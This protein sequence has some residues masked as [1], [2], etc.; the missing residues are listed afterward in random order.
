MAPTPL[1]PQ[2][3]CLLGST[4]VHAGAEPLSPA[5]RWLLRQQGW[6]R[7][8]PCARLQD[9]CTVGTCIVPQDS[10][11]V[12]CTHLWSWPSPL[13]GKPISV[14]GKWGPQRQ[15]GPWG[16][17]GRGAGAGWA[18]PRS[19]ATPPAE[20]GPES[21]RHTVSPSLS[22]PPSTQCPQGTSVGEAG[23][24][25]PNGLEGARRT[26]VWHHLLR[27]VQSWRER[28]APRPRQVCWQRA[29]GGPPCVHTLCLGAPGY[30]HAC[31]G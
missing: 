31:A 22:E 27:R 21:S 29:G 2:P 28:W 3:S 5:T 18:A 16:P 10:A 14:W 20:Q 17:A 12:V 24:C 11:H 9:P 1:R 13:W 6:V 26:L 19:A 4:D 25:P 15:G 7:G 23:L 30:G 8:E